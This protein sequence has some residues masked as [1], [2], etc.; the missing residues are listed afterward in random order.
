MFEFIK[1]I[2][3]VQ[4]FNKQSNELLKFIKKSMHYEKITNRLII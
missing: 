3:K 2:H 1:F 4:S